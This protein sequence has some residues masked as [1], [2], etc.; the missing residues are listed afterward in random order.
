MIMHK[1][2]VK[3]D[4][5]SQEVLDSVRSKRKVAYETEYGPV[6]ESPK[7]NEYERQLAIFND[8]DASVS[9]RR[10]AR[11]FLKSYR[12]KGTCPSGK[13]HYMHKKRVH[14]RN[15]VAYWWRHRDKNTYRAF[16][17]SRGPGMQLDEY[18]CIREWGDE[19]FGPLAYW[20][21]RIDPDAP[22]TWNNCILVR[23]GN[24]SR[25]A[26]RPTKIVSE[27]QHPTNVQAL[28]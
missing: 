7:I 19:N 20:F 10:M 5:Y 6:L 15:N 25:E 4:I 17:H 28:D 11:R 27:L 26:E 13:S 2:G 18:V 12:K 14:K 8:P 16:V 1:R 9:A 3:V 21:R 24:Y 23:K 22:L